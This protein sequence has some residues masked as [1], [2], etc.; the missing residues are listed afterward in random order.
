MASDLVTEAALNTL[1]Y[2]TLHNV[3]IQEEWSTLNYFTQLT[4]EMNYEVIVRIAV[5]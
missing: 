3:A 5:I 1:E 4:S 2:N